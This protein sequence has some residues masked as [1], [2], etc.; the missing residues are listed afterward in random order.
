MPLIGNIIK[1]A[2]ELAD[3]ITPSTSPAEQQETE[4]RELLYK[5]KDTAFGLHYN[6][7]EILKAPSPIKAF[8]DHVPFHDYDKI[9]N[10][11]WS[12]QLNGETSVTWPGSPSYYALS[13]GTTGKSS[14]RIPITDDMLESIRKTGV[15]QVLSLSNFNLPSDFFEKEV[16]MLGSSTSMEEVDGHYEAEISGISAGNIPKWFKGF[17]RPGDHIAQIDDW[18]EKVDKIIKEAPNWDIGAISGIPS[19]NELMLKRI[20]QHYKL[21]NIHEIWPNLNAFASGGVP[22]GPYRKSFEALMGKKITVIDT[23]LAS[24]GF[25]AYQA[26]PNKDMA[27]TLSTGSGIFFEFVPFLD[28]Y[29]D[30]NGAITQGAP[31]Y[32]LRDVEEGVDYAMIASTAA[33]AWRYMIGDTIQFTDIGKAEIIITGRTK[34]F[35]NVV[36]S[37][38]SVLKMNT[39]IEKLEHQFDVAIPEFT[40]AAVRKGEDFIHH[41]Y[42]GVGGDADE[43]QITEALDKTL[44]SANKNYKVA[45]SKALKGVKVTIVKPSVFNKWH[46][47]ERQKGGQIKMPR[48]MKEKD[49]KKWEEFVSQ[50][51]P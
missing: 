28:K 41:W 10:E 11:W 25:F 13:S 46:E 22:F 24:E 34:H 20:I 16:L 42:L 43:E 1:S 19:W 36:G 45:R 37:Q 44:Q 4:L 38:L 50:V 48:V 32:T 49:F 17:Y 30:D 14:K 7:T 35:L 6:F 39:A 27:M 21:N 47:A 40:V 8:A 23:Y 31:A 51:S 9:F 5:A 29:I 15:L 18:D 26:R 2:I 12:R 33:G 3:K